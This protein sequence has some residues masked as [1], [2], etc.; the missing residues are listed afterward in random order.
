MII[1]IYII[2]ITSITIIT[3][4]IITIIIINLTIIIHNI[5]CNI[6]IKYYL[7][8]HLEHH[9]SGKEVVFIVTLRKLFT[10]CVSR[11]LKSQKLRFKV[12]IR[13]N[14]KTVAVSWNILNILFYYFR[15]LWACPTHLKKLNEYVAPILSC[16]K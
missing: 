2:I 9:H 1:T 6:I 14:T 3:I 7:E 8:Y 13:R 15:V 10:N 5:I 12:S 11:K 16:K 4:I